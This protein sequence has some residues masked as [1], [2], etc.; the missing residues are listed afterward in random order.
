MS[1]VACARRLGIADTVGMRH[2]RRSD[3]WPFCEVLPVARDGLP[4]SLC[5]ILPEHVPKLGGALSACIA[6]KR[7]NF[8]HVGVCSVMLGAT[9][10]WHLN[11]HYSPFFNAFGGFFAGPAERGRWEGAASRDP[12]AS[13]GDCGSLW[14]VGG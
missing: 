12:A 6:G 4:E 11:V 2:I 7:P 1:L 13:E 8:V 9:H 10:G 14:G 3:D 5:T